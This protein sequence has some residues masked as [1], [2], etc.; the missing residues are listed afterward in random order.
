MKRISIYLSGF[1]ALCFALSG[2]GNHSSGDHDHAEEVHEHEH[3]DHEGEE[4]HEGHVHIH[5]EGHRDESGLIVM[6]HEQVDQLGIKAVEVMPGEFSNVIKV[7]G[8][9]MPRS[10]S[11]GSVAARQGGI[12]KLAKGI[13][14]GMSI[15]AGRMIATVSASAMAGGD[16]SESARVAYNA[17][18]RELDRITPLHKEGIVTTR[19]YNAAL[20][21]VEEARAAMGGRNGSTA[22]A[23]APISGVLTSI[24]VVDG[25]YVDAGQTIA[26]ISSNNSLMLRA[27][28][29][30]SKAGVIGSVTGAKFRTS[31]SSEVIDVEAMGGKRI[32]QDAVVKSGNGYLPIFFSLPASSGSLIGGTYCEVFLLGQPR[33]GVISVPES[34]VSEQQGKY[35]V[36][37]QVEPGHFRK[38]PVTIGSSDG[39]RREILSGLSAGDNV[40]VDGMT[41]VR[42]AESSGVVPEGHSH[43]H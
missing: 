24:D 14:P 34:S 27:D 33:Q 9:V 35:F 29:P 12:V 8:E 40:V 43:N 39:A 11:E 41:Y 13:T 36:Y 25:Q 30:E 22:A 19:D 6:E 31:Y 26:I 3:H 5:S 15:A 17:A 1:A 23:T 18:K 28:L 16:P 7:S 10:G 20:Q 2:C 21:R 32:S 42:L 4:G 37:V 38:Q